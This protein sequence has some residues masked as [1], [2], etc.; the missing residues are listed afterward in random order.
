MELYQGQ[1]PGLRQLLPQQRRIL[2]QVFQHGQS[3]QPPASWA[4]V[5][6]AKVSWAKVSWASFHGKSQDCIPRSTEERAEPMTSMRLDSLVR[7]ARLGTHHPGPGYCVG[8]QG[9]SEMFCCVRILCTP[10]EVKSLTLTVWGDPVSWYC[11]MCSMY[12]VQ[13]RMMGN[14][15][16]LQF[17]VTLPLPSRSISPMPASAYLGT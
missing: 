4:K 12:G 9:P 16:F 7:L 8:C 13:T 5:S 11:C 2:L 15:E 14:G 6:W 3:V 17:L 1:R 10:V